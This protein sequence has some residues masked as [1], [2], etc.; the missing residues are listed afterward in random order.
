MRRYFISIHCLAFCLCFALLPIAPAGDYYVDNVKGDDRRSG[1]SG[2]LPLRT[3]AHAATM[4]A[5]GD[6]LHIKNTATPYCETLQLHGFCASADKPIVIEG[7][8]A[9]LSGLLDV[10]GEKWED[11]GGGLWF[12]SRKKM[13]ANCRPQLLLESTP[14]MLAP[15]ADKLTEGTYFWGEAGILF[16]PPSNLTP[17]SMPLFASQI[18]SGVAVSNASYLVIRNLVSEWHA[19]DGFNIHGDSQCVVFENIVSRYNG[20]DGFSIHEDGTSVVRGGWFHHNSYGIEDVNASNSSFYGVLLEDNRTG[21]HFSGGW[22][23]LNHVTMRN[24]QT[25]LL[26]SKGV[27]SSYLGANREGVAFETSVE[28]KNVLIQGGGRAIMVGAG[29]RLALLNSELRACQSGVS[30][31]QGA[32][33]WLRNN[34]IQGCKEFALFDEGAQVVSANHSYSA[35]SLFQVG[36]KR[37]KLN[38]YLR[39]YAS[40]PVTTGSVAKQGLTVSPYEWQTH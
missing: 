11:Q 18:D 6:T 29:T 12:L 4:L 3:L 5:P 25:Q 37:F 10:R 14:L 9:V 30:L 26:L 40:V 8:M 36:D 17:A 15:A 16:F 13:P 38:E 32:A 35:D 7:N 19:N 24:N 28:A 20:D 1:T 39:L 22:H 31:R 23:L 34:M 27:G 33:A 2:E 21:A